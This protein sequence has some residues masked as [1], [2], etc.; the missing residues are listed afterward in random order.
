MSKKGCKEREKVLAQK[1][2]EKFGMTE[3]E[4]IELF[5]MFG[6]EAGIKWLNPPHIKGLNQDIKRHQDCGCK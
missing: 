1:Y 2:A 3:E 4:T 6:V 5:R